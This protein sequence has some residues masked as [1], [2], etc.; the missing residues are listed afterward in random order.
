[1]FNEAGKPSLTQKWVRAILNEFY[2]TE[3]IH[4][5][6]Y[7]QDEDQGQ[8]GAWYVIAS[9]GLFDMKGLTDMEPSFALGAPLFDKVTIRLNGKY[10]PGKELVITTGGE[11]VSH[12]YVKQFVWNGNPVGGTRLP[13][14]ELVKGGVLEIMMG[15]TPVDNYQANE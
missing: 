1:M 10:Y 9:M 3:G 8:L 7:G 14:R 2:G 11:A 5:Y 4:G 13:F 15:D 6:G 12:P